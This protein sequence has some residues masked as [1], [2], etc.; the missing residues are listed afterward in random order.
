MQT[1]GVFFHWLPARIDHN[2]A[3]Q[4]SGPCLGWRGRTGPVLH[5]PEST[6]PKNAG[7]RDHKAPSLRI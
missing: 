7:P 2:V 1:T 4:E 5:L 6:S 3:F